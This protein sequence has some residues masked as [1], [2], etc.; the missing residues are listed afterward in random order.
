MIQI[1]TDM[2]VTL[3]RWPGQLAIVNLRGKG[4]RRDTIISASLA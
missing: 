2:S 3:H 4:M 1:M